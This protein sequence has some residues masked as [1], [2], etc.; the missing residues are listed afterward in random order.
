MKFTTPPI[1]K[2]N[3]QAP[4]KLLTVNL[5]SQNHFFPQNLDPK[6]HS[7]LPIQIDTLYRQSPA[8]QKKISPPLFSLYPL[9]KFLAAASA[10][11]VIYTH[12]RAP[13][14]VCQ[15]HGDTHERPADDACARGDRDI[16]RR[17][18]SEHIVIWQLLLLL[19]RRFYLAV[20][21]R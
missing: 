1:V 2:I 8:P 17:A 4:H 3:V 21:E 15:G 14:G 12:T 16:A 6:S 10:N 11:F 18:Y 20:Y 5:N 13:R 9:S 7:S 19:R